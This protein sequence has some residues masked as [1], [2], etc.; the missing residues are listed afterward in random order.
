VGTYL[1]EITFTNSGGDGTPADPEFDVAPQPPPTLT[2]PNSSE[3]A[4]IGVTRTIVASISGIGTTVT[5]SPAFPTGVA[6]NA[7]TG[8]I[9]I[10]GTSLVWEYEQVH[11]LTITDSEMQTAEYNL[12]FE[13]LYR[14]TG[15]LTDADGHDDQIVTVRQTPPSGPGLTTGY[16]VTIIR[17]P[18]FGKR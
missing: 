1:P 12:T 2:Y 14:F 18:R 7:S 10:T 9:V 11:V 13:S 17:I 4:I 3:V 5:V 6:L 16:V 15:R 8:D